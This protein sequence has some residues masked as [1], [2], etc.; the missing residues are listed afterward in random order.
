MIE[1]G[2]IVKAVLPICNRLPAF[3]AVQQN[4]LE[5]TLAAE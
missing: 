1:K 3:C 2:R 4:P 5:E